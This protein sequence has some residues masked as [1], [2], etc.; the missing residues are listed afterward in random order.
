M[1]NQ[2]QNQKKTT[3]KWKWALLAVFLSAALFVVEQNAME[4]HASVIPT[5]SAQPFDGTT[6]PI[7]KSPKWT[8]LTSGEYK[9]AYELIPADK[10]QA[11]PLYDAGTLK[12]P[13]EQLGWK[14]ESDLAIRNAK[15]TFSVPYMGNY[16]LDGIE[17]AGS[18]LAV[19][20]KI[21]DNTPVYAIANG[22]VVKTAEQSSGFGRHA[23][24]KHDNVP[25]LNDPAT[26]TTLYSSYNHL[27]EI[28]VKEGDVVTKGQQIA[29]SGHSGLSTTPHL[30]FQIDN[31]KAPW[32]PYWPFTYQEASAA[33]LTFN[34]AI[35][36]GLGK[37]KA[38]QTTVNPMMYVQK[39][40]TYSGS[41]TAGITSQPSTATTPTVP[42][43]VTAPST[44]ST[45]ATPSAPA[46]VTTPSTVSTEPATEESPTTTETETTTVTP[47]ST[48]QVSQAVTAVAFK[49]KAEDSSFVADLPES[50][51][52]TA[53]DGEGNT[54]SSYK[55]KDSVY[56]QVLIG[57]AT[58]GSSIAAEDF[59]NG[60]AV[61]EFT[62]HSGYSLQFK[63]SDGTI[64]GES[65][66]LKSTVFSDVT[67]GMDS[68]KAISFLKKHGLID[69]YPDG[70]FKPENIV[71]RVEA[72]KFILE[73]TNEKL[74]SATALP[75]KDTNTVEWY[76]E[77]VATA[78]NKSIVR[79]YPDMTFKPANTVNRAE[80]LKMLLVS[81]GFDLPARVTADVYKDV[82]KDSWYAVYVQFAKE[83]NLLALSGSYFKPNE[84]MTRED[85]AELIYR[86]II[87]KVS[88]ADEY[89]AGLSVSQGSLSKYLN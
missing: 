17:G 9:A 61:L 56:V 44:P 42:T 68:Y 48:N 3:Q 49:F 66:V 76:T 71:S 83:K 2:D 75:F 14:S 28:L 29:K 47:V 82:K 62:P 4:F 21:P 65:M 25:S 26:K 53:V 45:P 59:T 11:L 20:I 77:Y 5:K 46:T 13:T 24:I 88:G 6:L 54:V 80:F 32:H 74:L 58:Y 7:L 34:E 50:M 51:T 12:T 60:A 27:N 33:G 36:A 43:T 89:K 57:S 23:V 69:G 72:V 19:D 81:M 31:D 84:G 1:T 40:L 38:L 63:V 35:D 70:T 67:T 8:A 10:L 73:A 78:Y 87:L 16:K 86:A 22:V 37:D 64:S 39:Y 41:S 18:H 30:H 15:I 85:V 52:I 79:G 55:P